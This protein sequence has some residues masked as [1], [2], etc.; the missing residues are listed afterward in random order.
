MLW[1]KYT[2][3][4][5]SVYYDEDRDEFIGFLLRFLRLVRTVLA[6]YAEATEVQV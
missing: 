6:P 2:A 3:S 4:T 1:E 5:A